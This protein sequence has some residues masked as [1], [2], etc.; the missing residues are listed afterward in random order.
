M[1]KATLLKACHTI[2]ATFALFFAA[3]ATQAMPLP[4]DSDFAFGVLA[5]GFH[6]ASANLPDIDPNIAWFEFQLT[7]F[8]SVALDTF[9]SDISDTIMGLYDP[10]GLL[11]GDN[12]DCGDSLESC[13]LF[14]DL[15][16]ASYLVGVVEWGFPPQGDQDSMFIS[17]WNVNFVTD[18]GDNSA[19]LNI[20][21]EAAPQPVSAPATLALFGLGL[22]GLGRSRRK[23][24]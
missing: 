2:V 4:P 10:T 19:T 11:L 6:T 23:K 15:M 3:Q 22:A 12:D 1:I 24:A 16:P 9:G 20:V 17:G 18:S 21:V 5:P 14:P 13:L 8:S 7:A